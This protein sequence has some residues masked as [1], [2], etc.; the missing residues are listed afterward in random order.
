MKKRITVRDLARLAGCSAVTVSLALRNHPRI[1]AKTRAK[2]QRLA[3]KH[4]YTRD[5]VVSTLMNRLRTS[6]TGRPVDK[7]GVLTWWNTPYGERLNSLGAQSHAGICQRA[8]SLGYDVEFFWAKE[9]GMTAR[10]LTQILHTRS[11]RGLILTTMARARGHVSLDWSHFAAAALGYSI[12]KPALHRASYSHYQGM[13]I[14]LRSLR[15]RGYKR[16]GFTNLIAQEDMANDAWL[17]A[18]LGYHYRIEGKITV[19]PLLLPSWNKAK[20]SGWME[21]FRPDAVISN[22]TQPMFFLKERGYRV[23][24]DVGFASLDCM[25]EKFDYAGVSQPRDRIAAKAVDLVVEQLENHEFGLPEVPKIVMVEGFWRDG[26]TV[27][28]GRK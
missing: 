24:Q 23:P 11:I 16:I 26:P 28:A 13:V 18:Y 14:A 2:V 10:R 25:P 4:G 15:S 21:K 17:S 6:R 8:K 22:N 27:Q 12:L 9:P 5:P 1:S 3:E 20:V 7:L 19:P